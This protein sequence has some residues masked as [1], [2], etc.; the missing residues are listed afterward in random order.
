PV[1]VF[2]GDSVGTLAVEKHDMQARW[3]L[4]V[5]RSRERHP[6]AAREHGFVARR[7]HAP[8]TGASVARDDPDVPDLR[9]QA[10]I[11]GEIGWG[12]V[13]ACKK[14]QAKSRHAETSR[15]S[16]ENPHGDPFSGRSGS[17][18]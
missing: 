16:V 4:F 11:G 7:D 8:R 2:L 9:D 10:G 6:L 15:R 3:M 1:A 5:V 14:R 18:M 12:S 17:K 13:G